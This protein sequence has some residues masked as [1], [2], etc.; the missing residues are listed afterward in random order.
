[1][2][3]GGFKYLGFLMET[4]RSLF[5]LSLPTVAPHL[6]LGISFFTFTQ[7]A[8][9]VDTYRGTAEPIGPLRYALFVGFFP[10]LVAGPIVRHRETAGQFASERFGAL[11]ADDLA[12]GST[13][14]VFGLFKKV[15]LADRLSPVADAVF[16]AAAMGIEPTFAEAWVGTLAFSFQIYFDFSGY[17]DM[18]IGLGRILGV[19]LPENFDSPY[20]AIHPIDFWSRWHTSLSRFLRD[21]LYFPMY[22]ARGRRAGTGRR[23][24]A[25]LVTFLLG[26]LWHGA[27]WT[28][29]LWGAVMALYVL[30]YGAWATIRSRLGI[31]PGRFG[32]LGKVLARTATFLAI[33]ASM[34]IFRAGSLGVA[35][36]MVG[37]LAGAHGISLPGRLQGRL[38]PL[39]PWL[40]SIGFEF[41]GAF[42]HGLVPW[43]STLLG[44]GVL[45]VFVFALPNSGEILGGALAERRAEKGRGVSGRLVWR[46]TLLWALG[47]AA[48]ALVSIS[49]LSRVQEFVYFRF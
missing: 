28:F 21:Y 44:L 2:L 7:I 1:L 39:E 25:I 30:G 24:A 38:G 6:P 31:A 19:R 13:R 23:I 3:L 42:R 18:A 17:S 45:A 27:N 11:R 34:A 49:E 14:L 29:V 22:F 20:K 40:E 16:G 36:A 46:P 8:F 5:A 26:G 37:S 15:V 48:A 10:Q 35:A 12:I 33:A 47:S 43:R 41:A 4:C 32:F 9:L